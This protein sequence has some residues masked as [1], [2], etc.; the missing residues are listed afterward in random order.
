MSH[1]GGLTSKLSTDIANLRR[2][3]KR[4]QTEGNNPRDFTD[5]EK[6]R[7]HEGLQLLVNQQTEEKEARR[8][9]RVNSHTT[10]E[11][12]R[13]IQATKDAAK[14]TQEVVREVTR[15]SEAYFAGIGGPGS[16]GDLIL[17]GQ[18]MVARGKQLKVSEK[19][20]Q[21]AVA[22]ASKEAEKLAAKQLKEEAK[23]AAATTKATEKASAAAEKETNKAKRACEK[24]AAQSGGKRQRALPEMFRKT[25]TPEQLV[26]MVEDEPIEEWKLECT[27]REPS[28]ENGKVE[29]LPVR[30]DTKKA[31]KQKDVEAE[32]SKRQRL[33]ARAEELCQQLAANRARR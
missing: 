1:Q 3:I 21:V 6:Q 25:E 28:E 24:A 12:N 13:G 19:A 29:T 16:S 26:A 17:Q 20:A 10:V 33:A 30:K 2:K 22:K 27:R 11:M 15:H 7:D 18:A 32:E 31:Q 23:A 9:A 14:D 5:E 8:A 4:G